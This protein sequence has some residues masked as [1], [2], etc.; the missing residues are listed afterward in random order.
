MDSDFSGFLPAIPIIRINDKGAAS[1]AGSH[2]NKC[3]ARFPGDRMACA[4][5]GG[6]DSISAVQLSTKGKLYNYTIVH[7]S[8]PGV[9]VPFVA[10]IVDL[11]DGASLRGTLLDVEPNPDKLPRDLPVDMVFR[12][13]G[14]KNAEGTPFVSYFFAPAQGAL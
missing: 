9:K 10:A 6:R 14:Q 11:D 2:C 7:R 1:V 12:D 3:D 13:T 4:S 5:C 8:F